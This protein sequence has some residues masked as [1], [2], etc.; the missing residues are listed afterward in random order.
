MD[1]LRED[2]ARAG[3]LVGDLL[4]AEHQAAVVGRDA[5]DH[6]GGEGAIVG[7]GRA[8]EAALAAAHLGDDVVGLAGVGEQRGDGAEDLVLVHVARG[9]GRVVD[10]Q[11]RRDEVALVAGDAD[12]LEGALPP[13]TIFDS[14]ARRSMPARM[15]RSWAAVASGPTLTPSS[16]GSPTWASRRRSTRSS[17]TC[18]RTSAG[19]KM[20][21]IAVHFCPAFWVM[22]RATSRRN[23]A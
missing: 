3:G 10:E 18:A 14:V 4:A 8:D 1:H 23:M 19:A 2:R 7:V 22:S 17:R 5:D 15:S 11:R 13:M 16:A 21:R 20:R 6:L 9:V 12:L